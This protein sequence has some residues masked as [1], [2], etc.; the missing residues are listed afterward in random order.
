M[1]RSWIMRATLSPLREAS[2]SLKI[3]WSAVIA[4]ANFSGFGKA[5]G[6]SCVF[7]RHG[8]R[9][10]LDALQMSQFGSFGK[11]VKTLCSGPQGLHRPSFDPFSG[12]FEVVFSSFF[13]GTSATISSGAGTSSDPGKRFP[14]AGVVADASIGTFWMG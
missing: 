10:D 9:C 13:S 8:A 5:S 14:S 3:A 6:F 12:A 1:K 4:S 2:S 7:L 11:W